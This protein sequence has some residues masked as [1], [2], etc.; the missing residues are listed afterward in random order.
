MFLGA[1]FNRYLL[2]RSWEKHTSEQR[3]VAK[4]LELVKA[5]G[6]FPFCQNIASAMLLAT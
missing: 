1:L 6:L 4:K 3:A 5:M 2:L